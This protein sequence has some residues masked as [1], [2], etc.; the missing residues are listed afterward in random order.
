MAARSRRERDR[1]RVSAA[2]GAATSRPA[3]RASRSTAAR[4]DAVS[5]PSTDS[6]VIAGVSPPPAL[7]KP[8]AD[9]VA[10]ATKAASAE[11]L[12]SH[13]LYPGLEL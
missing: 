2:S 11:M 8:V 3:W 6:R 12:G 4:V 5:Q 9:G 1:V 13:P 7:P 10:D